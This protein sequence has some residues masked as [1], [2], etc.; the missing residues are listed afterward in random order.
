MLSPV[1]YKHLTHLAERPTGTVA[2]A[3]DTVTHAAIQSFEYAL[4]D[5]AWDGGM[6]SDE[7]KSPVNGMSDWPLDASV[8]SPMDGLNG[9]PLNEYDA[10]N[11]VSLRDI[12]RKLPSWWPANLWFSVSL[13]DERRFPQEGTTSALANQMNWSTETNW[14][15][16]T[17][18]KR[19]SYAGLQIARATSSMAIRQLA[20]ADPAKVGANVKALQG[21]MYAL[22]GYSE[23]MLADLFCSGV[24]L[25]TFDSLSWKTVDSLYGGVRNSFNGPHLIQGLPSDERSFFKQGKQGVTFHPGST[26]TQVYRDAIAKFDTA[27][28]LAHDSARIMDLARIGKGRALLDLGQYDSAAAAVAQV[29]QRFVYTLHFEYQPDPDGAEVEATV[30]DRKGSNGLPFIFEGDPRTATDWITTDKVI[31]HIRLP[32]KYQCNGNTCNGQIPVASWEEAVLIQA[33]AALHKALNRKSNQAADTTWLSLLNMLRFRSN[34]TSL[35][36]PDGSPLNSYLRDPGTDHARISRLFTERAYWLFLTGHRQ[37][38]LRRLV[39][40]YHWPQDQVYPTGPYVVPVRV[41]RTGSTYGT[42][43]NMPIPSEER[44][45]PHFHGC[46]DRGP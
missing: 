15:D 42:D 1:G 45:N 43:V 16:K 38:D 18:D 19:R 11:D 4:S 28:T 20:A 2:S 24:P 26:T 39:R 46:L 41:I 17:G 32:S 23:I 25:N 44:A 31:K 29:Q 34:I 9:K 8:I 30:A 12:A 33:E 7:L 22:E 36:D 37:G 5:A 21:E 35:S 3:A 10:K 13:K 14:N 40:E 6:L 27:L